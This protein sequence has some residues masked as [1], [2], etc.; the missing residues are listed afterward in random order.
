M[1]S[2]NDKR[3]VNMQNDVFKP[4]PLKITSK[5]KFNGKYFK[6]RM[7]EIRKSLPKNGVL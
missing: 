1:S 3:G 7:R 4:Q 5:V 6:R 2:V